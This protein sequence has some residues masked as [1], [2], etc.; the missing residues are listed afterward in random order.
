MDENP[1]SPGLIGN[2]IETIDRG[3]IE[4]QMEQDNFLKLDQKA[5]QNHLGTLSAML[6]N[7]SML[8]Y[9]KIPSAKGDNPS[10]E[11][12]LYRLADTIDI[13]VMRSHLEANR[14][15]GLELTSQC[16][17]DPTESGFP[18]TIRD[19]RTLDKDK[20]DAAE[21][22]KRLPTDPQ[23]VRDAIF[24]LCR[25]FYP[26]DAIMQKL[27]RNFYQKVGSTDIVVP[28]KVYSDTFIKKD[29]KNNGH[30]MKKSAEKLDS[31]NNLPRFYT[32]Y[33][34][35]TNQVCE[36]LDWHAELEKRVKDVLSSGSTFELPTMAKH[37][38]DIDGVILQ[39]I[40]RF[41]VGPFYSK[42][43]L[44]EGAIAELLEKDANEFDAI[45]SFR[46][47]LIQRMDEQKKSGIVNKV[48]GLL[49]GD[50][51]TGMF[52]EVIKSP[53]YMLMPHR[54]IQ[55]A[56]NQRLDFKDE[57]KLYGITT[58]GGFCG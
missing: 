10:F 50:M 16:I 54:L 52:S 48:K 51:Y 9:E 13:L 6:R 23:L 31:D 33:F 36:Q 2:G 41:D 22:L 43:T 5:T 53:K 28:L 18:L 57:V 1:E 25:G 39:L 7:L 35:V 45:L 42:A 17:I 37:V 11:K 24:S 15:N 32:L 40:E 20:E 34:E 19:F 29:E 27:E 38:E 30:L 21:A 47:Y 56:Y 26:Q 46:R 55:K 12:Y 8:V 49:S 44:N 58:G 4:L 14:S 3:S